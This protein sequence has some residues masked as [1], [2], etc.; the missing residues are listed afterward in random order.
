MLTGSFS[1]K[2]LLILLGCY[3]A[4]LNRIQQVFDSFKVS[5]ILLTVNIKNSSL[6]QLAA[7]IP[8]KLLTRSHLIPTGDF[9]R[10]MRCH[11]QAKVLWSLNYTVHKIKLCSKIFG[12]HRNVRKACVKSRRSKQPTGI[13]VSRSET[14]PSAHLHKGIVCIRATGEITYC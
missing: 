9:Q 2:Y 8:L 1:S 5:V 4:F 3:A 11:P 12:G 6:A 13:Q 7:E 10:R 14:E